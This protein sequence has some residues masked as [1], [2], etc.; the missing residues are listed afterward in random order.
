MVYENVC[1]ITSSPSKRISAISQWKT[2]I[3]VLPTR[4]R[5]KPAGIEITSLSPCVY[6]C[7][8]FI[9]III[10]T[11]FRSHFWRPLHWVLCFS[12]SLSK[13]RVS[14]LLWLSCS[15]LSR[16]INRLINDW[17]VDWLIDW[18]NIN[19]PRR[20]STSACNCIHICTH[21]GLIPHAG[22]TAIIF[23]LVG[24]GFVPHL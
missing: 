6:S 18:L 4:W 10:T 16:K 7:V 20:C 23:F 3:T 11:N 15:M 2:F 21:L 22:K 14:I 24:A 13:S 9:M 17:L 1:M 19:V 5:R 12:G 8:H